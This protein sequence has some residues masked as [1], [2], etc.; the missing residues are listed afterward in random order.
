MGFLDYLFDSDF[1]QREDINRQSESIGYTQSKVYKLENRIRTLETKLSETR[2]GCKI[3]L[4]VA[5]EKGLI[6]EEDFLKRMQDASGSSSKRERRGLSSQEMQ[7]RQVE[8][9]VPD[10]LDDDQ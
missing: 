2:L 5:V 4:E 9:L 7:A 6:T 3:L 1:R 8:P 10:A